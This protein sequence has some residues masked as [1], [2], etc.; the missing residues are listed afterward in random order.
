[1]SVV[2]RC[3]SAISSFLTSLHRSRRIT[4]P[5]PVSISAVG[6]F[7]ITFAVSFVKSLQQFLDA[8]S[9]SSNAGQGPLFLPGVG[10]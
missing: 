8:P 10:V 6:I 7:I 3:A 1:M 4:A 9:L 2:S 5:S